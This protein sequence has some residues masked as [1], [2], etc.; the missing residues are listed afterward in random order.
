[1]SPRA[2]GARTRST[3]RR[4]ICSRSRRRSEVGPD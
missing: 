3:H 4:S 1:V 2:S